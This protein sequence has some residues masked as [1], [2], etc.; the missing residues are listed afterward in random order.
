MTRL[1]PYSFRKDIAVT[2][3]QKLETLRLALFAGQFEEI[4]D[5][6]REAILEV[7][8]RNASKERVETLINSCYNQQGVS[9]VPTISPLLATIQVTG[10]VFD[11]L[12]KPVTFDAL[13]ADILSAATGR[14]LV[15]T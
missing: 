13:W 5:E 4:A 14:P 6:F 1:F 3:Q 10:M 7:E 11:S 9:V 12:S 8:D 15:N 2:E